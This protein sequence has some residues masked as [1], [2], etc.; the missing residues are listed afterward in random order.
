[1]ID[2]HAADALA[3]RIEPEFS[4][5]RDRFAARVL[6]QLLGPALE[7]GGLGREL[8]GLAAPALLV[9]R[10]QIV[11]E[12]APRD[13]VDREVMDHQEQPRG[14]RRAALEQHGAEHRPGREIEALLR[15]DRR[16]L[17]HRLAIALGDAREIHAHERQRAARQRERLHGVDQAHAE[18]VVVREET[19]E[20]LLHRHS[21]D[22]AGDLEEAR[23]VVVV[24]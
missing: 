24:R 19:G 17:D 21:V 8:D 7:R 1:M 13:A 23:L 9:R 14:I 18:S 16:L 11:E 6:A 22:P 10:P 5:V 20:R 12:N 15:V 3:H 2:R 4:L